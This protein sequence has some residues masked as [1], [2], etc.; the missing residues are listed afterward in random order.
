MEKRCYLS[1]TAELAPGETKDLSVEPAVLFR[2]ERLVVAETPRSWIQTAMAYLLNLP[3]MLVKNIY[4]LLDGSPSSGWSLPPYFPSRIIQFK[5]GSC[6]QLR[7]EV[8]I[9]SEIFGCHAM[10]LNLRFDLC[11]IGQKLTLTVRNTAKHP[12]TFRAGILGYGLPGG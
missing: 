3:F 6:E 2:T 1:V 10:D 11:P 9:P 12:I 7:T 8:G 5:V 4:E